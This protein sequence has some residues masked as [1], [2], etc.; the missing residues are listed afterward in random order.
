LCSARPAFSIERSSSVAPF[1]LYV[2]WP[3]IGR[4]RGLLPPTKS[5]KALHYGL[6]SV[7]ALA[8]PAKPAVP[9]EP[10]KEHGVVSRVTFCVVCCL[11]ALA[12]GPHPS[13][14]RCPLFARCGGLPR[15]RRRHWHRRRRRRS[16]PW[17]LT[18]RRVR[19]Q[20]PGRRR[21]PSMQAGR[22]RQGVAG[23]VR[24]RRSGRGCE[25]TGADAGRRGEEVSSRGET[26]CATCNTSEATRPACNIQRPPPRMQHTA[27]PPHFGNMRHTACSAAPGSGLAC[28]VARAVPSHVPARAWQRA[29]AATHRRARADTRPRAPPWRPPCAACVCRSARSTAPRSRQP[30]PGPG[31][32]ACTAAECGSLGR[33]SRLH[34]RGGG[35][36]GGGG[37]QGRK[38]GQ[39]GGEGEGGSVSDGRPAGRAVDTRQ[40]ANTHAAGNG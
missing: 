3:P 22:R 35:G 19:Q 33:R 23:H 31:C 36:G 2:L 32:A 15:H 27:R 40:P 21:R 12:A 28:A 14:R 29:L 13:N 16:V 8:C 26:D 30:C 34:E 6:L 18:R 37:A 1:I 39:K 9:H 38:K 24:W 25:P 10:Q 20:R 11:S 5:L 4:A 7:A 17:H